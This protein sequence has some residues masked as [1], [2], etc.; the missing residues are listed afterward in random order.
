M[1]SDPMTILRARFDAALTTA[2]ADDL[3]NGVDPL[4]TGAKNPEH[5]DFQANVAM[6]LG[7]RLG[8]KPR[9]VAEKLVEA[10]ELD[11]L[12]DEPTIAGPGFINL[13][14]KTDALGAALGAMRD[15]DLGVPKPEHVETVAVDLC[16]VNLAKQMHVGHLRATVIGDAIARLWE[17]L[18]HTVHRQNHFGD[19]GLP[20]AMVTGTIK[21]AHD[22]GDV[23]I[24]ALTLG[25]LE[26]QY[27]AAQA[28]AALGQ[29]E[30]RAIRTFKM[31]SKIE[32]EWLDEF[33]RGQ[34]A[35]EQARADLVRLQEGDAGLRTIWDRISAITLEACFENCRRLNAKVTDEAT[36]GESTYRD[37]LAP[38]VADLESRGVA[39]EDD[40][41]LVVR[42]KELGVKTP[43]LIRKR[44]GAFLY[45]T[46]DVCAIRRRVQT[47]GAERLFYA[48][49]QRQSLHFQQV[50]GAA[51]K[52]GYTRLPD[53]REASMTHAAFGMVMGE[54]GTPFKTRSGDNV[55][56]ADLLDEAVERAEGAVAAKNPD[57]DADERRAVA[58]AVG[59]GAIKHADLSNE[60]T[61]DYVFG[62][63]RM[64]AFE[65]DTGPYL[66]YAVVR[67]RS[68]LRK[69]GERL[70]V[71]PTAGATIVPSAPEERA[72]S[73]ALLRYPG[74]LVQAAMSAE[75][76]RLCTALY[77]IASAF[78]AFFAS[79]PALGA[80]DDITRDSRLALAALTGRTL[81][82]GLGVLGIETPPRM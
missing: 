53:G 33:E 52:A 76:H 11:D 50:F 49:D 32:A 19:W 27:R 43:C 37:E 25:D 16:G 74:V 59:I 62:F 14:L 36:A 45:A 21:R 51:H 79:C 13:R 17:R 9:D 5:G 20:I 18:G 67:T 68:M 60:R 46:T 23:D 42:L 71:E 15:G 75:P 70:G 54:D 66:Q 30:M 77:E 26:G 10:L 58:E 44:D 35:R 22:A 40:G 7:K 6:S 82:D 56:L 41:A 48:V 61:R 1:T 55:K 3:P 4:I 64:L 69:A 24:E 57:L 81:T 12:C 47:L 63:D 65:G 80:D 31:G 39:E 38:M 78:S 34:S 29:A 2:F 28:E 72:L 8:M 73:L